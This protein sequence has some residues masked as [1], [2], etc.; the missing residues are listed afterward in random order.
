LYSPENL[1][2]KYPTLYDQID[3]IYD[4][5]GIQEIKRQR[6]DKKKQFYTILGFFFILLGLFVWLIV[7]L[8]K[9]KSLIQSLKTSNLDEK[10]ALQDE[11]KSKSKTIMYCSI[12]FF[13]MG[14]PLDYNTINA[15]SFKSTW[16]N[17]NYILSFVMVI[18]SIVI[19]NIFSFDNVNIM[20]A[21]MVIRFIIHIVLI[22]WA[23]IS[24]FG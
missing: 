17:A 8:A 11:I 18:V 20:I 12:V 13:V 14:T 16:M 4:E 10:I 15:I 2:L 6:R 7:S 19:A 21:S 5:E 1:T 24:I 9:L 23:I 22:F 3:K